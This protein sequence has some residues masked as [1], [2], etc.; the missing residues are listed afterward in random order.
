MTFSGIM[1]ILV[2]TLGGFLDVFGPAPVIMPIGF[3]CLG[4]ILLSIGIHQTRKEQSYSDDFSRIVTKS[5]QRQS[6]IRIFARK[7]RTKSSAIFCPLC[8]APLPSA[9]PCECEYCG[10]LIR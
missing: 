5:P 4:I 8:K 6:R 9:P 3:L 7:P 10:R 2:T 1:G